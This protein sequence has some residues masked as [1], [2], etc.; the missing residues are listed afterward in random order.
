MYQASPAT[1]AGSRTTDSTGP[2]EKCAHDQ[3]PVHRVCY[4]DTY[5]LN[6]QLLCGNGFKSVATLMFIGVMDCNHTHVEHHDGVLPSVRRSAL[7]WVEK[8]RQLSVLGLSNDKL[9]ALVRKNLPILN[10]A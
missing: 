2:Q 1:T 5:K 7:F 9:I 8:I 10:V 3:I 4:D 6:A